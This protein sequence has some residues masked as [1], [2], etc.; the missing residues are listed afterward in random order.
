MLYLCFSLSF[1]Y[2]F[3]SIIFLLLSFSY[4]LCLFLDVSFSI[5]PYL[6]LHLSFSPLSIQ[7]PNNVRDWSEEVGSGRTPRQTDNG[8]G[9]GN[10][11]GIRTGLTVNQKQ[12]SAYSRNN[13]CRGNT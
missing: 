7:M 6:F 13:S 10:K 3:F 5:F 11:H 1:L 12:G 8:N 9:S 2:L 4:Y